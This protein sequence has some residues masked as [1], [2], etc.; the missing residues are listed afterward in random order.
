MFFEN[1]LPTIKKDFDEVFVTCDRNRYEDRQV[2]WN[3]I[4]CVFIPMN[5]NSAFSILHGVLAFLAIF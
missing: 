2:I 4:R 1:C 5:A 3:G